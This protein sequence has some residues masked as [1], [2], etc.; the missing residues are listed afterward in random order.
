MGG[1]TAARESG[2]SGAGSL[3]GRLG[4]FDEGI[5]SLA[6]VLMTLIPLVEI[7][8]RPLLG[9]GIDNAPVIVQHLGL[10]LAMFGA[11]LAERGGHLTALGN[12][13]ATARNP[14][15]RALSAVFAKV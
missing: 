6:L 3:L 7:A 5:A 8:L 4:V 10:A 2:Q 12:G 9:K 1:P 13:F 15:V 14:R 11:V